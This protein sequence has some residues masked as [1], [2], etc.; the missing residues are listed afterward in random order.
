MNGEFTMLLSLSGKQPSQGNDEKK[1][2][3]HLKTNPTERIPFSKFVT[4][5]TFLFYIFWVEVFLPLVSEMSI[6]NVF[7]G[8]GS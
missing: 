1:P 4:R 8:E 7:F 6:L 3:S 5:D 2:S